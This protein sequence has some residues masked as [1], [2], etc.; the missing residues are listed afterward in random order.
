MTN[1]RWTVLAIAIVVTLMVSASEVVADATVDHFGWANIEYGTSSDRYGDGAGNDRIS[2]QQLA[3]GSRAV[4]GNFTAIGVIG[5]TMNS[6]DGVEPTIGI[7]DAFIVWDQIG[8]SQI[9]VS[10]GMQA[11]LFGLKPNGYPGDHSLNGSLEYGA[12]GAVAVSNQTGAS[13]IAKMPVNNVGSLR[14][15]AFDTAAV[16]DIADN[17]SAVSDNLFVQLDGNNLNLGGL[18]FS[19]GFE[20][21]YVGGAVDETANIVGAGVGVTRGRIDVSVEFFQLG[22]EFTGTVDDEQYIVVESTLSLNQGVSI[23]A[24][25]SNASELDVSTTRAG[26][27][28]QLNSSASAA[29]EYALDQVSVGDDVGSVEARL[30]LAF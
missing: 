19:A 10:V 29:V 5:A 2:V 24:D 25:W 14:I 1:S 22:S 12:M 18:Y 30:A 9:S 28:K 15:G 3:F 27:T 26:I 11:L 6:H 23:Y 7:K 16:N 4:D 21:A 17:G 20:R 8:G 13:I